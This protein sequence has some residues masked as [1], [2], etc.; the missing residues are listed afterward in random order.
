MLLITRTGTFAALLLSLTACATFTSQDS[1]KATYYEASFN[2]RNRAPASLTPPPITSKDGQTTLDPLYMRTQ[3]DY[4]FA[5]G[6]AYALEGN[7][8]K[9]IESFKMTLVYDQ[10]S[11]TV[12]MR[13]AAEFLKLGMISE[14][15]AQAEEA[16]KKDPKNIDSHLL[17][18]GLYS[19]MKLYPKAMDQYQLV[20]KLS[21]T[22]TEAPLY[23]G[24]LYSEQKQSDKAVKYFESLLKNPEYV[25]PHLAHYYIGRVRM[26]QPEGKYQKAAE[27]SF[28]TALKLKPDF[29]DG[30]LTLGMLYSK[31]K[32]DEKALSLYRNFQKEN[33]PS[34]KIADVLAQ[35]YIEQGRYDLAYDQLEVLEQNSEEPLNI[36]MKMALIL[37][38]QKRYEVAV[39]KLEQILKEAPESD[40]IRFYLAAVYEETRQAE[41]A[42]REFKKI[43]ASSTYYGESVVHAAYLLKG[44]GRLNEAIELVSTGLKERADQ[45][46]VYAMY[47]SLLDEKNDFKSAAKVLEQGLAKF[48]ENAQLRFYFGTI[49][50]RMGNKDIVV[51]EML[52]VLELDPNHV[53][54]MNYL[55]FTWAEMN[56]NLDEA[57]KLARRATELEP[58]DGYVLDTLGWILYKQNKVTE[59]IKYL[60]AA[61]KFQGTVSII[62]EHLGDAYYRQSMIDKAKKMYRKAADLETDKQKVQE[63]RAKITAIE[64]QELG[65]PRLP[66]STN[67][68][69]VAADNSAK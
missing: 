38:E 24:A 30:V 57:E 64:R 5:M 67:T 23:I 3:A 44:L 53:Q 63:I 1:D 40:K 29:A 18:G 21:P 52:K 43:P 48:P 45:P 50:D 28:K 25:T 6:E 8:N 68:T 34:P 55:A 32:Q 46:Q 17:L 31:Q 61:H 66:A 62:A 2:D 60:E 51:A 37:I 39:D 12:N 4:Y 22:N 54:G 13:L 20:M 26:E 56:K 10:N 19:S 41:K 42:V 14:S 58:K 11:P 33:T 35:T 59:S 36:K 69:P 15:L 47:A 7:S 49:N 27:Q 16:T 9:A 65:S